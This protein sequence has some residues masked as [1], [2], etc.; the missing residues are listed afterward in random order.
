MH[1]FKC[2]LNG[3]EIWAVV[4]MIMILN[5]SRTDIFKFKKIQMI[6]TSTTNHISS[7]LNLYSD[8]CKYS[9]ITSSDV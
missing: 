6:T 3:D 9:E 5:F 4:D 7:S 2:K 1:G 8:P